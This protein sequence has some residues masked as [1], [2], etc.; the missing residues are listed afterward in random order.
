VP[1]Q[2]T[3][4]LTLRLVDYSETSQVVA[5]YSRDFGRISLLAKGSKRRRH[6]AEATIDLFKVLDVVFLE[7][8]GSRLELLT[9]YTMKEDFAGLRL[10]VRRGYSAFFI[11]EL[12][13]GL[14]E[15]HDPSPAIFDMTLDALRML[16]ETKHTDLAVH[17]YEVRLLSALGLLP[18]LDACAVCGGEL[19][20][21]EEVAFGA[22]SGG[23]LCANCAT[24]IPDRVYVSRGALAVLNKLASTAPNKIERLRISDTMAIDVRRMLSRLWMHI[25]GH[26]PQMLRY[27]R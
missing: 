5:V 1:P 11:A 16:C 7:R 24:S 13:L 14:T 25:M 10:D 9:E 22:G 18:R 8:S 15:E 12:L 19:E 17:S 6:G 2:K 21:K 27:L 4:A 20:A 23:A 26:E 3:T